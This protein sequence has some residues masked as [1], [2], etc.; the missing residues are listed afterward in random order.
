MPSGDIV[1][2]FRKGQSG[3]PGGRPKEKKFHAALAAAL[4][5]TDPKTG[6]PKLRRIAENLVDAAMKGDSWAIK[7]VADRSDGKAVQAV[8]LETD[9]KHHID[10]Y[11]D[12][13]LLDGIEFFRNRA[14]AKRVA[15]QTKP[16]LTPTVEN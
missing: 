11:S 4:S 7:E 1:V 9:Q 5:E 6:L 14:D 2:T 8:D 10:E 13:E 3:N 12:A 16:G 15:K